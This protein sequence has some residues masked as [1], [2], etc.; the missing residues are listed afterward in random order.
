MLGQQF[1]KKKW[2][3]ISF[4]KKLDFFV[5]IK[6]FL[7]STLETFVKVDWFNC[8]KLTKSP[9]KKTRINNT[10]FYPDLADIRALCL[11][12]LYAVKH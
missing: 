12:K 3:H 5:Q 9:E 10:V 4:G 2:C 11:V 7:S 6:L 1:A 8:N